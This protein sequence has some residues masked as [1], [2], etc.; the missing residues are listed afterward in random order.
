MLSDP[1]SIDAT[2]EALGAIDEEVSSVDADARP[3]LRDPRLKEIHH[4]LLAA[5]GDVDIARLAESLSPEAVAAM[6]DLL[7]EQA[8][9]VNL[10]ATIED[11]ITRLKI[12]WRE[13]RIAA[14]RAGANASNVDRLHVEILRL[15]KEIQALG[16]RPWNGATR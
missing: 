10:T 14:L 8:S 9:V 16:Q 5:D 4:A 12:R 1:G 13:E 7:G 15:V 11:S 6:E 3:T 2:T